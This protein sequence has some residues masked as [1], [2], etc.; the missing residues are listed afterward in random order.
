VDREARI[1]SLAHPARY[2]GGEALSVVK[3]PAQVRL[4]LALTFPE[5]YEIAMSHLGLKVLYDA[6]AGRPEVAA[7]RVFAPWTDLMDLLDREGLAPWSLESGRPLGDFDVIGFSQI[8]RAH[9]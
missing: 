3:D 5:V 6:L 8:G 4:T 1:S 7:E 2:L 9:V